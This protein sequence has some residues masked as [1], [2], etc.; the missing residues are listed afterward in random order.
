MSLFEGIS[1]WPSIVLRVIGTLLSIRL[2]FYTLR[3]LED[4]LHETEREMS[5]PPS[6]VKLKEKLASARTEWKRIRGNKA[7][8]P[9]LASRI[10]ALVWFD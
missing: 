9:T 5:L 6:P 10:A 8:Y 2:I 3:H 7:S 4:N 1:L